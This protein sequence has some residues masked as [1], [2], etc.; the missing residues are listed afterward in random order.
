LRCLEHIRDDELQRLVAEVQQI[1]GEP[2]HNR[3]DL[4]KDW[5]EQ[6]RNG[7]LR[8]LHKAAHLNKRRDDL[9]DERLCQPLQ[10]G[11]DPLHGRLHV[12]LEPTS[13][14]LRDGHPPALDRLAEALKLRH[15]A[16]EIEAP[17]TASEG[18]LQ[19]LAELADK[20]TCF[21]EGRYDILLQLLRQ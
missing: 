4:L 18:A 17:P 20:L 1:P 19:I 5:Q 16:A 6:M 13:E 8:F 11:Q 7:N 3:L 2:D 15:N 21:V 14:L 9:V 12:V 10:D